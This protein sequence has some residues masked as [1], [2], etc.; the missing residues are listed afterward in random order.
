LPPTEH[1]PESIAAPWFAVMTKHGA[2]DRVATQIHTQLNREVY[3][4]KIEIKV[5]R[6]RSLVTV[7][8]PLF[9]HYLFARLHIPEEWKL[10]TFTRGSLKVLGGWQ[11]PHPVS[12][13]IIA[14]IRSQE[15][16]NDNV[17]QY[18]NFKA[19]DPV[20]ITQGPLRDLHGIFEHYVDG[21]GRVKV[22][23]SLLNYQA[24]VVLEASSLEKA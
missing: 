16:D 21:Y 11:Q 5:K 19:D 10:I 7:T 2:E 14:F 24:S 4:P 6:S 18:Y 15:R 3:V 22:L 1:S 20:Y 12:E 13:E 17:I 8:R 9:P 23:L